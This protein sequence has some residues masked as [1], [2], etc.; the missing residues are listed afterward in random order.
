MPAKTILGTGAG[1]SCLSIPFGQRWKLHYRNDVIE[2]FNDLLQYCN[3]YGL[4]AEAVHLKISKMGENFRQ[5]FPMAGLIPTAM[6][7]R[8]W[9]DRYWHD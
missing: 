8:G 1:F 7:S 9:E 5:T 4:C 6:R 2:M 3:H